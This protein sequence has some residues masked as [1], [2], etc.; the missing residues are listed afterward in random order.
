[1]THLS[2]ASSAVNPF[3]HSHAPVSVLQ[4]EF[5]SSAVHFSS[6]LLHGLSV[7]DLVVIAVV[8]SVVVVSVEVEMC[9]RRLRIK[10]FQIEI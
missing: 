2:L 8:V 3:L 9:A 5:T 6:P 4:Y 7:D 10:K 1:M